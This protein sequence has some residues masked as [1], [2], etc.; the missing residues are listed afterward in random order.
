MRRFFSASADSF[1]TEEFNWRNCGRDEILEIGK[2]SDGISRIRSLIKFYITDISAS[3]SAGQIPISAAFDLRLF[4]ARAND[5]SQN[6]QLNFHI[7]SSSWTEGS[8]YFYQN[9]NVPFTSSRNPQGGFFVNDGATW[10]NKSSGSA[11]I[12]TGSDYY[13]DSALS[14]SVGDPVGDISVDVTSFIQSWVSGTAENDGILI[15]FPDF[16]EQD[17][18]NNGTIDL[19][20][21]QTHTIHSPVLIAK[22]NDQTYITGSL[23]GSDPANATVILKNIK[24]KYR[25]GEFVRIDLSVKD[26][27]PLKQFDTVFSAFDGNQKLPPTSYY[28]IVD[29][30]SNTI[31][32]PFDEN[33]S[34]SCDGNNSYFTFHVESLY[35]GRFY[36]TLIKVINGGYEQIYDAGQLFSI[37]IS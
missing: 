27:Y 9:I 1:I 2:S 18:Y 29:V 13:T 36:K 23:T 30:Q 25:L 37:E 8:G 32:I 33:S 12:S 3:I 5:L 19:F 20:S 22:W 31:I 28:S 11:W 14:S 26:R 21:R 24:S 34:I 16:D 35:P 7:V 10:I 4:T 6:Q 15:K 17:I